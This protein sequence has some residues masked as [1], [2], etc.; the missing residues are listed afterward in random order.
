MYGRFDMTTFA[1]CMIRT[2]TKQT[3][4]S[5]FGEQGKKS[6]LSQLKHSL[7]LRWPITTSVDVCVREKGLSHSLSLC[8]CFS[9]LLVRKVGGVVRIE[10]TTTTTVFVVKRREKEWG[11]FYESRAHV[12]TTLLPSFF[13]KQFQVLFFVRQ[14]L[15]KYLIIFVDVGV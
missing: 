15:H 14:Y 4:K 7:T 10:E 11:T 13:N 3:K 9:I 5:C 1:G 2:K 8:T 12:T 6:V